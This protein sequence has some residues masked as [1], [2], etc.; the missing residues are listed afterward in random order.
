V[1]LASRRIGREACPRFTARG[2]LRRLILPYV[3]AV[4]S[5]HCS[6]QVWWHP[7]TARGRL[8]MEK[9]AGPH[10]LLEAGLGNGSIT[11]R[12]RIEPKHCGTPGHTAGRRAHR[13]DDNR[14]LNI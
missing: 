13:A 9:T 12:G 2:R 14:W 10:P 7:F 8:G 1:G 5:I 11:A 6:W 4:P 3:W